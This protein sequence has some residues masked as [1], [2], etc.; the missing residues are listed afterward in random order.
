MEHLSDVTI[1]TRPYQVSGV[2]VTQMEVDSTPAVGA[3][4]A[5]VELD[6][7]DYEQGMA[8]TS[9]DI[10]LEWYCDIIIMI[11]LFGCSCPKMVKKYNLLCR[12][13]CYKQI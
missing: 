12:A 4:S 11:V 7:D 6:R 10:G 3:S 5:L 13:A 1:N 2:S 8:I 9:T